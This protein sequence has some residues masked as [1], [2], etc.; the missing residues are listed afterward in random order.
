MGFGFTSKK[1]TQSL[2]WVLRKWLKRLETIK[3]EKQSPFILE[4]CC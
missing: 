2:D 3:A 4:N 1:K